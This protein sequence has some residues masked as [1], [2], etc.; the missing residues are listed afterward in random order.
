MPDLADLVDRTRRAR[1]EPTFLDVTSDLDL[2]VAICILREVDVG[3]SRVRPFGGSACRPRIKDAMLAALLEAIQSR[4][5]DIAGARDDIRHADYEV[6]M[7]PTPELGGPAVAVP[8]HTPLAE[9][10]PTGLATHLE[11]RGIGPVAVFDL[12]LPGSGIS[13]VA[14]AVTGLESGDPDAIGRIGPRTRRR[15]VRLLLGGT[16]C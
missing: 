13:C 8:V 4:G 10:T 9:A 6:R 16:A 5:T 7:G 11:S 12:G 14:V 15:L 1:L 2:P 3:N